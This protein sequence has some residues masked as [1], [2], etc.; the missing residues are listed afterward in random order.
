[1][2]SKLLIDFM[3]FS[4]FCQ[5]GARAGVSLVVVGGHIVDTSRIKEVEEKKIVREVVRNNK[6]AVFLHLLDRSR[7][8]KKG[9]VKAFRRQAHT[10]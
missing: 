9:V 10:F 4:A 5:P 7:N 1:M 8:T 3:N 6:R 2:Y